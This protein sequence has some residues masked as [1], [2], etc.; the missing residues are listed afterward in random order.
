MGKARTILR[1][2]RAQQ[3]PYVS[4]TKLARKAGLTRL[5]YWAIENGETD[6]TDDEKSALARA[7]GVRVS[8]VEW[9]SREAAHVS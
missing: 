4:Q 3:E 8:D 9:P 6:A 5:R 1:V 7:L 2:L